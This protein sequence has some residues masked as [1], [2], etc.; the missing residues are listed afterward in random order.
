MILYLTN[1]S[2]H[3]WTHKKKEIRYSDQSRLFFFSVGW[4]H[5]NAS[6]KLLL[7]T[8]SHANTWIKSGFFRSLYPNQHIQNRNNTHTHASRWIISTPL[9]QGATRQV[10][11]KRLSVFVYILLLTVALAEAVLFLQRVCSVN[12]L[13]RLTFALSVQ[14]FSQ[15]ESRA[16]INRMLQT[17]VRTCGVFRW[18]G[19]PDGTL[20]SASSGGSI[21]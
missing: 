20:S 14:I 15:L 11:L 12:L 10:L 4:G 7:K 1:A 21:W 2:G 18:L 19:T 5:L 3:T 9:L 8:C 6:N 16:L 13:L 17:T